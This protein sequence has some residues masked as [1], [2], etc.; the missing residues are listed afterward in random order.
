MGVFKRRTEGAPQAA[1][2]VQLRSRESH[3]F[4]IIDGYVPLRNGELKLYRAI[5]E[6][7]P[8]VDAAII[9]MIRL[10][11][12]VTAECDDKAAEAGLKRFLESVPTGRGQRGINSFVDC[13]LD[14]LITCGRAVGEMVI[15][16]RR[17]LAA[18][19]C[20]NVE[21]IQIKEEKDHE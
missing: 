10:T 19:L 3:P 12:G 11:G 17:E 1:G 6:A 8:V 4:S 7:V 15:S 5:R 13:Y 2:A 21:D 16:G 9:K 14:S 18:V 20:G